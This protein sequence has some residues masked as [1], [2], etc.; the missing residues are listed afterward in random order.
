M[1]GL[2]GGLFDFSRDG[3]M[4]ILERMTELQFLVRV[5]QTSVRRAV[6]RKTHQE[7]PLPRRVVVLPVGLHID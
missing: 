4:S 6:P 2:F 5:Q 3:N 7:R 1:A